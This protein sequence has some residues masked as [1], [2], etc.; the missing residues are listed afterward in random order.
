LT[1]VFEDDNNFY[2]QIVYSVDGKFYEV[3]S[4]TKKKLRIGVF[5][6]DRFVNKPSNSDL[7]ISAGNI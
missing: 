2:F 3:E 7:A 4:Y 6:A 5:V 1:S